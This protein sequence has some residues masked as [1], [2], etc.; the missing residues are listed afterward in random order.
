VRNNIS[1]NIYSMMQTIIATNAFDHYIVKLSFRCV[2]CAM[3][4]AHL[5][6]ALITE[7]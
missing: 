1:S 7:L 3:Y 2:M 4:S 5:L 6:H